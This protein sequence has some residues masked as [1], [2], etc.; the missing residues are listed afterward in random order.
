MAKIDG[1][2]ENL[3]AKEL[4]ARV[5][6]LLE[7]A[8][9]LMQAKFVDSQPRTD[10]FF[11]GMNLESSGTVMTTTLSDGTKVELHEHPKHTE[12][13]PEHAFLKVT[14][15]PNDPLSL[16][17][18]HL[19]NELRGYVALVSPDAKFSTIRIGNYKRGARSAGDHGKLH[20]FN[21]EAFPLTPGKLSY[22]DYQGYDPDLSMNRPLG[23]STDEVNNPLRALFID[24]VMEKI[25][26][27]QQNSAG[28][29]GGIAPPPST[30]LGDFFRRLRLGK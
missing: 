4:T 14:F 22:I 29:S 10:K 23:S 2:S 11:D 3:T 9:A 16:D 17:T 30:E 24:A 18:S 12:G 6:A 25:A 15:P 1:L 5:D 8:R 19:S 7:C 27:P 13:G 21:V 28:S 20:G 26:P